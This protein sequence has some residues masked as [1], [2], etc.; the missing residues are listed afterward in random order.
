MKGSSLT[1]HN[2]P[3]PIFLCSVCSASLSSVQATS[4]GTTRYPSKAIVPKTL[5]KISQFKH[6]LVA[7]FWKKNKHTFAWNSG[8]SWTFAPILHLKFSQP[9]KIISLQSIK[10]ILLYIKCWKVR[11]KVSFND[12]LY[13]LKWKEPT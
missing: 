2:Y 4:H 9:D 5:N 1:A 10:V 13:A 8:W 12:L 6:A 7:V 11:E 3:Y